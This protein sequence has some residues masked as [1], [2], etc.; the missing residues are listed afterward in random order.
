M[1]Q[2]MTGILRGLYRETYV[3]MRAQ[4]RSWLEGSNQSD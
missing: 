3:I 1:Q 4:T 2:I